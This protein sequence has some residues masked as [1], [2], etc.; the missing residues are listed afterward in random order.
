ME[1]YEKATNICID[2]VDMCNRNLKELLHSKDSLISDLRQKIKDLKLEME[3]QD[4]IIEHKH[5]VIVML[6]NEIDELE[7]A[8]KKLQEKN[9]ML[10]D[11]VTV[12]GGVLQENIDFEK[13]KSKFEKI[14]QDLQ[15]S[16]SDLEKSKTDLEKKVRDLRFDVYQAKKNN[17]EYVDSLTQMNRFFIS[18]YNDMT[19]MCE[20]V[21]LEKGAVA[22]KVETKQKS[23]VN[24]LIRRA[25]NDTHLD[26]IK[27]LTVFTAEKERLQKGNGIY[28]PIHLKFK[29]F[30]QSYYDS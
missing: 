16:K 7:A 15:K 20:I 9:K 25:A 17:D 21:K 10:K 2:A 27:F 6:R 18:L 5:G 28:Q 23:I 14:K 26:A 22:D 4:D 11:K 13:E 29:F 1:T 3:A 24:S 19:S 30:D 12:V 8:N